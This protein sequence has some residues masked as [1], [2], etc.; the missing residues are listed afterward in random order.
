[1]AD[2]FSVISAITTLL[3]SDIVSANLKK[4]SNTISTVAKFEKELPKKEYFLESQ[5][6]NKITVPEDVKSV[7]IRVFNS[8]NIDWKV[9]EDEI[10]LSLNW[11]DLKIGG[12]CEMEQII[13][14]LISMSSQN[15]TLSWLNSLFLNH[16]RNALF[17]CTMLHALSHMEYEETLPQ[18]PTMAMASLNHIDDR[19]IGYAIKAFSNWNSKSTINLMKTNVPSIPWAKKEWTKVLEHIEKYGDEDYELLDE[20]DK[21]DERVDTRT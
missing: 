19:V 13:R 16:N 17:V 20:N 8:S 21:P 5:L 11:Q 10:F 18:G 9:A 7:E 14:N 4:K 2:Y 3:V 12:I 1:M 6:P 15:N